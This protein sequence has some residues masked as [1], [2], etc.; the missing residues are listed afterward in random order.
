MMRWKGFRLQRSLSFMTYKGS[1]CL[2]HGCLCAG[3]VTPSFAMHFLQVHFLAILCFFHVLRNELKATVL[4]W[5]LDDDS[6]IH[7]YLAE[8]RRLARDDTPFL[9]V[10]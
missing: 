8:M 6:V 5:C 9:S 1:Y 3:C 7:K 4:A 2:V 10:V